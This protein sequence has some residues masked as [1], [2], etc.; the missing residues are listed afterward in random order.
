M[1][2]D[3]LVWRVYRLVLSSKSNWPKLIEMTEKFKLEN[4][5]PNRWILGK[6]HLEGTKN[7]RPFKLSPCFAGSNSLFQQ[8]RHTHTY[9]SLP[10]LTNF[11]S[12][13]VRKVS[14]N[15]NISMEAIWLWAKSNSRKERNTAAMSGFRRS[16]S[17]KKWLL[18]LE[19]RCFKP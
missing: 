2:T 12:E 17:C 6:K 5:E 19:I 1:W 15:V 3:R 18:A 9:T 13:H 10:N 4:H 11:S 7:L 14:G 8:Q 16:G